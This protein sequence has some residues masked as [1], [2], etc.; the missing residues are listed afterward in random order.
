MQAGGEIQGFEVSLHIP[1]A[2]YVTPVRYIMEPVY[3][4]GKL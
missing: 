3:I 1:A 2:E 4:S